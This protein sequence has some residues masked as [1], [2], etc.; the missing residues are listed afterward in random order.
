MIVSQDAHANSH[1][2]GF[3]TNTKEFQVLVETLKGFNS[4]FSLLILKK[5]NSSLKSR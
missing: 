4:D 5:S 1:V 3:S 2:V